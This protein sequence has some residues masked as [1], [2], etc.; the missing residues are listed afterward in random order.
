MP[1]NS[2]GWGSTVASRY[3]V[4]GVLVAVSIY[5]GIGVFGGLTRTMGLHPVS[6]CPEVSISNRAEVEQLYE[7]GLEALEVGRT[8]EYYLE[9]SMDVGLPL[10]HRAALHGHHEAMRTYRGFME[11]LGVVEML[12][13]NG[14]SSGDAAVESLMWELVM[15]HLGTEQIPERERFRYAVLLDPERG[16]PAD[17][18][19][20]KTGIGWRFQMMSPWGIRW[21]R[22]QAWAWRD[23]FESGG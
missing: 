10:V 12:P 21:A 22:D 14:L 23:C 9:T 5:V 8:G 19:E 3:I 20:D 13:V 4:L 1:N 6:N 2:L 16:F 17:Y 11:T 7:S 15:V 18:Y